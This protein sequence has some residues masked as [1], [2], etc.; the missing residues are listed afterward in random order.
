[1][2]DGLIVAHRTG[3]PVVSRPVC[4]RPGA[5]VGRPLLFLAA[6]LLSTLSVCPPPAFAFP[7]WETATLRPPIALPIS[8]PMPATLNTWN[9][10][11]EPP[12]WQP[13]A[14]ASEFLGAQRRLSPGSLGVSLGSILSQ[15]RAVLG[16]PPSWVLRHPRLAGPA[17]HLDLSV[18]LRSE[19]LG[20]P[21]AGLPGV[22]RGLV[23]SGP[24]LR[25]QWE[26][27]LT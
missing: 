2:V 8:V 23:T 12:A 13:K 27:L 22:G 10:L 6:A 5:W 9:R 15:L 18:L 1:M 19:H 14:R 7:G 20:P 24:S 16:G 21:L 26:S 25:L 3:A 4:P 11:H 17:G